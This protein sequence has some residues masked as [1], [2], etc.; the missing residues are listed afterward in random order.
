LSS[1][2][3]SSSSKKRSKESEDRSQESTSKGGITLVT[4]SSWSVVNSLFR[5]LRH[6][7]PSSPS[8]RSQ[9]SGVRS[10]ELG[11][12]SKCGITQVKRA[13]SSVV[14]LVIRPLVIRHLHQLVTFNK[15]VRSQKSGVRRTVYPRQSGIFVI[16]QPRHASPSSSVTFTRKSGVRSQES[17]GQYYPRQSGIFV[18]RP[19][20]TLILSSPS[21]INDNILHLLTPA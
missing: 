21:S 20:V 15:E 12:V 5:H 7:S 11:P 1:P 16:R 17:E 18:I 2:R 3:R 13:S 4:W 14:S 10:Q 8:Q 6:S 19:L 9:E